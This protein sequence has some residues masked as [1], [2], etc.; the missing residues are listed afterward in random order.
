VGD[1]MRAP[2]PPL[3]ETAPL[4]EIAER[5]LASS[6]NFLPVV[7]AKYRLI[8]VVALQDLKEHLAPGSELAGVIAYDVMRPAPATV[9]PDQLLL[10]TLP[11]MLASELRN[12]P[13]VN[14]QSEN[15]LVGSVARA[16]VLG[17]LSEAI[18]TNA[19]QNKPRELSEPKQ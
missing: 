8:G 13:V 15:R 3:R 19:E 4:Q 14:S 12:V 9:T 10:D 5:F 18:A 11:I 1:M 7:D 16:E 6:N 2:V 17:L